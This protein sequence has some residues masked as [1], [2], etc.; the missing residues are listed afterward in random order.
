M[1]ENI[2][3]AIMHEAKRMSYS[4]IAKRYGLTRNQVAGM[5]WREKNPI[6]TRPV[7]VGADGYRRRNTCGRGRHGGGPIPAKTLQNTR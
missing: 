7:T 5:I 1:L 6:H 2:R 3:R 4:L